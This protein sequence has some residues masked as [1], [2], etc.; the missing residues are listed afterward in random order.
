MPPNFFTKLVKN[1]QAPQTPA[2]NGPALSDQ[3]RVT[4]PSSRPHSQTISHP[5]SSHV[6]PYTDT[7][8]SS[9][10]GSVRIG[11]IPP[12]PRPTQSDLSVHATGYE[13]AEQLHQASLQHRR[14]R[15]QER[16]IPDRHEVSLAA[17]STSDITPLIDDTE[18][19]PT[20]ARSNQPPDW[21]SSYSPSSPGTSSRQLSPASSTGNLKGFVDKQGVRSHTLQPPGKS[22]KEKPSKRSMRSA[23]QPPP[24]LNFDQS[25][26]D[27]RNA[28]DVQQQA[29]RHEDSSAPAAN[30]VIESPAS[31]ASQ[32]AQSQEHFGAF[33]DGDVK[34]VGSATSPSSKRKT[35]GRRPSGPRN[36]NG[37]A[38]GAPMSPTPQVPPLPPLPVA[39]SGSKSMRSVNSTKESSHSTQTRALHGTPMRSPVQPRSPNVSRTRSDFSDGDL[40]DESGSSSDELDL[41]E[42]DIPVTGFAV[43]SNKRNADFHELF[44]NIPE[45]D[46]LIEGETC[47]CCELPGS[48]PPMQIMVVRYNERF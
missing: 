45:G 14:V 21:V 40:S 17:R 5:P 7:I 44:P 16:H 31:S 47:L 30:T 32:K 37:A 23:T 42:Q 48:E 9:S 12:S 10:T 46:Y 20:P 18:L 8:S 2:T 26:T 15:S 33:S 27:T 34:S 28:I 29:G 36:T 22:V 41:N 39:V 43:A 6:S 19:T 35:S 24:P 4:A 11:V 13:P 1:A 38:S 3:Q 25:T